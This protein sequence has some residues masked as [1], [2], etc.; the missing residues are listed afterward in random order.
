MLERKNQVRHFVSRDFKYWRLICVC[1]DEFYFLTY[2]KIIVII[3]IE[4]LI[5]IQF[6]TENILIGKYKN[7]QKKYLL[8][9]KL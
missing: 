2:K 3:V 7:L 1:S 9:C 5:S 4:V 8:S 6:R